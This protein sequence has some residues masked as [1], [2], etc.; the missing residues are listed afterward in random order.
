MESGKKDK[1]LNI[2]QK[3]LDLLVA[4]IILFPRPAILRYVLTIFRNR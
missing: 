4:N 3:E 1:D 2:N